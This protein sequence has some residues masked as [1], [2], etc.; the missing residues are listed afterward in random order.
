VTRLFLCWHFFSS[1][2][3]YFMSKILVKL[4][5]REFLF[6]FI[7]FTFTHMCIHCLGSLFSSPHLG[8]FLKS[9]FQSLITK[10]FKHLNFE[11]QT[12]SYNFEWQTSTILT[13]WKSSAP[14][15]LKNNSAHPP[16]LSFLPPKFYFC[17]WVWLL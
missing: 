1:L 13:S 7:I 17:F 4:Q 3:F 11:W 15:P 9:N 10:S 5:A 6:Y 16:T 2:L 12:S 14:Y 8:N